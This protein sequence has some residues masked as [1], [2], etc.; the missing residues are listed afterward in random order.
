MAETT[1]INSPDTLETLYVTS[2]NNKPIVYFHNS[3]STIKDLTVDGLGKGNANNRMMGISFYN[4]GGE[5]QNVEIKNIKDTPAS[6]AQHG[7]GLYVYVNNGI[8]RL[9]N[10]DNV[11]IHDYQKNGTVFAGEGLA[12]NITNS[13]IKGLGNID[14][15]AQNG[16]QYSF[17]ATGIA[18]GNE[19]SDNYYTPS[20]WSAAGILGYA[21]GEG[22]IIKNN[23][24]F[25]NEIGIDFSVGSFVNALIKGNTAEHNDYGIWLDTGISP[26]V[27]ITENIFNNTYANAADESAYF[28]DNDVKGNYWSDY[29]GID[30][31]GDGI[32]ETPYDIDDDSSDR[33]PLTTQ[34]LSATVNY[35]NAEKE[36]Y[37]DGDVLS[38]DVEVTNNG[39]IPLD[40]T[41]EQLVINITNPSGTYISGTFRGKALLDL[42]PGETKIYE[43]YTTE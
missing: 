35:V 15:N 32:G 26:T 38:I 9:L 5:V 28:Y 18:Q 42:Q 6:G 39:S 17:G 19:I 41:K 21:A 3:D 13:F 40:P 11:N 23:D 37:K 24:I 22:L 31:N 43:F 25:N 14:F 36:Y 33:Y 12:V 10:V 16:I 7:V 4:A 20:N 1:F 8:S 2:G 29:T 34:H 30:L 27:Q